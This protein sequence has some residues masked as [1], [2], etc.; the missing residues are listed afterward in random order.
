MAGVKARYVAATQGPHQP[1]IRDWS[2]YPFE[3]TRR[4]LGMLSQAQS[5]RLLA[6]R[7]PRALF[8]LE[9]GPK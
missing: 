1:F 7:L 2:R 4:Q 9:E 6:M 5:M 8:T 3:D